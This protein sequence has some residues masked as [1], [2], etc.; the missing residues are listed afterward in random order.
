MLAAL[1]DNLKIAQLLIQKGANGQTA[2]IAAADGG[3]TLG[4][5]QNLV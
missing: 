2:L 5:A 3:T 4:H 1:V